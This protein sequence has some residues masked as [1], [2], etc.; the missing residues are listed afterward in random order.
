VCILEGS[1]R[2]GGAPYTPPNPTAA[3]REF[4]PRVSVDPNLDEDFRLG[5]K[6]LHL[7][8]DR[9]PTHF[10]ERH[11]V[12]A[13][14]VRAFNTIERWRTSNGLSEEMPWVILDSDRA[15]PGI[16][17]SIHIASLT[18]LLIYIISPDRTRWKHLHKVT[19]DHTIVLN[20]W[21]QWELAVLYV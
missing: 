5:C 13:E 9:L 2:W 18:A 10:R 20:P 16:P 15:G 4:R 21:S 6:L 11:W 17:G 19:S 8:F 3:L 7:N 1:A 12:R 14:E